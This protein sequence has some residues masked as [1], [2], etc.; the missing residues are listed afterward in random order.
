MEKNE[1]RA[2]TAQELNM[3]YGLDVGSL[4]NL[5]SQRRGPKFFKV[6]K[7]VYYFLVDVEAW[8]RRNP[9]LTADCEEVSK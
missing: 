4:A 5:R 9:V 3:L 8:L 1:R 2:A 7:R 6:G